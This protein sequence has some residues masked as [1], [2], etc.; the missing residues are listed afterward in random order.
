MPTGT[1]TAIAVLQQV[2][3]M[4]KSSARGT[5]LAARIGGDQFAAIMP[6]PSHQGALSLMGRLR[7]ASEKYSFRVDGEGVAVSMSMGVASLDSLED[8][9]A[10]GLIQEA[11]RELSRQKQP[12]E[13]T[14]RD[15]C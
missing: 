5:D 14:S 2:A 8:K 1:R 4:L 13:R 9:T 6:H 10:S 11:D 12:K 7:E 3:Q 15:G